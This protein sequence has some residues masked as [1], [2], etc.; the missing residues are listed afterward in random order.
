MLK[1]FNQCLAVYLA[2]CWRSWKGCRFF[3]R[4]AISN[5]WSDAMF[6]KPSVKW[7]VSDSMDLEW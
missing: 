3:G 1:L 5:N 4:S 7:D 6:L 2:L